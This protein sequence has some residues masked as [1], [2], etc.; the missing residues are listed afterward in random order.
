MSKLGNFDGVDNFATQLKD[1]VE[2]VPSIT[3]NDRKKLDHINNPRTSESDS[4]ELGERV[5][6]NKG[7]DVVEKGR[8]NNRDLSIHSQK[9]NT[10]LDTRPL[11]K[12]EKAEWK[13]LDENTADKQQ[14]H[15]DGVCSTPKVDTRPLSDSERAEW[16]QLYA[17]DY[18]ALNGKVMD[19]TDPEYIKTGKLKPNW[20]SDAVEIPEKIILPEGTRV[21]QYAHQNQSGSYFAPE[22]TRYEDL[23]LPDTEDKREEK[24]YEVQNGGLEVEKSE[25]AIQ[26]WNKVQGSSLGTGAEQYKS[27]DTAS[28][29]VAKGR[30]K[31]VE[32][33]DDYK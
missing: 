27:A 20:G 30:L 24:I 18:G 12:S 4:S 23:Q 16:K 13:Q 29:L 15:A 10:I 7:N 28:S 26:P 33:K 6:S 2:T 21:V 31:L 1:K 8:L 5:D 11:S 22:G 17:N 14:A 19:Y 25:V 32:Q 9:P 3:E